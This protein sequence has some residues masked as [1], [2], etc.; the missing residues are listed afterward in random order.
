MAGKGQ[1]KGMENQG[2]KMGKERGN[3]RAQG[4]R[5]SLFILKIMK[6]FSNF[7]CGE[8]IHRKGLSLWTRVSPGLR[9]SEPYAFESFSLRK[10][11]NC[12]CRNCMYESISNE[13]RA[14]KKLQLFKYDR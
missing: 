8:G 4:G 13:E 7:F 12:T 2:M 3:W 1:N 9:G 14:L 10:R 6:V 11:K 5:V